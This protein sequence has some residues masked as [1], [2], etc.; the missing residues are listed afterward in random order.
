MQKCITVYEELNLNSYVRIDIRSGLI[1]DVNSYPEIFSPVEEE[2]MNDVIIKK[3]YDFDEFLYD[4][5]FDTVRRH[6]GVC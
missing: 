3:F 1:I 6:L 5:L 2:D 4:L